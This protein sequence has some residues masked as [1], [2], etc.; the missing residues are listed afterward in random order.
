VCWCVSV[1]RSSD[2][3]GDNDYSLDKLECIDKFCYFGDLFG[4][5]RGAEEI[6]RSRVRLHQEWALDW[7][8]WSG[9]SLVCRNRPT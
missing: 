7:V 9:L 1:L 2:Y 6:S 4:G 8:R 5:G 3:E